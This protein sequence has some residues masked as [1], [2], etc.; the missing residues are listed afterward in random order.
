M[1]HNKHTVSS[2][3]AYKQK[4]KNKNNPL[5]YIGELINAFH[6]I[7]HRS[8]TKEQ[9]EN[10]RKQITDEIRYTIDKENLTIRSDIKMALKDKDYWESLRNQ[11][12][13]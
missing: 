3:R 12:M 7:E 11:I 9:K 8:F 6:S 2:T 10:L 13:S 1:I 4:V 5:E